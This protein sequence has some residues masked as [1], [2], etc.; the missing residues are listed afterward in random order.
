MADDPHSLLAIRQ[1]TLRTSLDALTAITADD[2]RWPE[3]ALDVD[4]GVDA[5]LHARRDVC[6]VRLLLPSRV[7]GATAVVAAVGV[8]V[9]WFTTW[10]AVSALLALAVGAALLANP[11]LRGEW[12]PRARASAGIASVL[13]AA[14]TP[15]LGGWSALLVLAGIGWW[16]TW[17]YLR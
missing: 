6:A 14:S 10:N 11:A 13:G 1:K 17:R 12:E 8:L 4:K 9:F 7:I 5:V 2:P 16:A 3:F 15:L